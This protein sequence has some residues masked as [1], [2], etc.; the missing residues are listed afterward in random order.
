MFD[1]LRDTYPQL[2]GLGACSRG[3]F[4]DCVAKVSSRESKNQVNE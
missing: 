4:G 3:G 2:A 1:N